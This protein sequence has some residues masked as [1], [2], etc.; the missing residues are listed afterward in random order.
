M[1]SNEDFLL[2][3]LVEAGA[4]DEGTLD[5]IRMQL[6]PLDNI[7][8]YLVEN[9][10][11]THEYIAQIAANNS[12][13]EYVDVTSFEV[14]PSIIATVKGDIHDIGKNIVKT[15][16]ENYGYEVIDLGKDVPPQAVV[17]KA[18]ATGAKL[19]G[20]S[21]LMTTTVKA[22]EETIVL[23]KQSGC[24]VPVMVGGAVLTEEFSAQIGA[25]FYAKD[26]QAAVEIAKKVLG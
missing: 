25:D 11:L 10:Y 17:D 13:L 22:M 8:D 26:A 20:L 1:Y 3:L 5:S 24:N 7:I 21:A 16:M 15:V 18:V 6:S 9:N 14:D 23:L 12:G 19:V 2:Q 4:I